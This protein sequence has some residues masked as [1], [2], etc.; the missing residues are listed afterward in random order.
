MIGFQSKYDVVKRVTIN[1]CSRFKVEMWNQAR[2]L[3]DRTNNTVEGWHSAFN[4]G[5][6]HPNIYEAIM[7]LKKEQM[8]QENET[9]RIRNGGGSSTT[10]KK[11]YKDI[12]TKLQNLYHF[13]DDGIIDP[14]EFLDRVSTV[15]HVGI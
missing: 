13:L 14:I 5:R 8:K 12:N 1:N 15:V 6:L 11:K 10:N 4:K 3:K 2:N 9:R 7:K